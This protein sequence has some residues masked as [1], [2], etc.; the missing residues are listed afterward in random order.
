[1][2]SFFKRIFST[3]IFLGTVPVRK[4]RKSETNSTYVKFNKIKYNSGVADPNLVQRLFQLG[5]GYSTCK[6][7][8]WSLPTMATGLKTL[9]LRE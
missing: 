1:M 2:L 9:F 3:T 5:C 7:Q 8:F 6:G 4:Y